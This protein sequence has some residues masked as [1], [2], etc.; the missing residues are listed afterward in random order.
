MISAERENQTTKILSLLEAVPDLID[1]MNHNDE[2]NNNTIQITPARL[3]G[4]KDFSSVV[5]MIMNLLY[6]YYAT[7]KYH[8]K[9]LDITDW[10][11]DQIGILGWVQG[12]SS[13]VLIFFF[14]I[15]KMNLITK[16]GWRE[17]VSS[18][19]DPNRD[20]PLE[21]IS[22]DERL[23]STQMSYEMTHQ[24]LMIKGPE[25]PE[26]QIDNDSPRNFGNWFTS[27][28]YYMLNFF[29]FI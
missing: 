7:R 9:K 8:F 26:F 14:A 15:N 2:L 24:I 28:E 25:A 21:L 27:S 29:F 18:N 4:L 12:S 23:T 1:E 3:T 17:Y 20:P 16:K 6:V 11:V 5:G 13:F 10:V 22:N 19:N